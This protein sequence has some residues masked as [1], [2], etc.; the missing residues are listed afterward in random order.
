LTVCIVVGRIVQKLGLA[1]F[2]RGD[3]GNSTMIL[4]AVASHNFVYGIFGT[5]RSGNDINVLNQLTA[6]RFCVFTLLKKRERGGGQPGGPL[7]GPADRA[8]HG[9]AVG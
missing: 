2:T 1:F 9:L 8:A 5:D 4:Q 6:I 7:Q 3:K